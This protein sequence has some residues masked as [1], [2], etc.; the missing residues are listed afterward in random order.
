MEYEMVLPVNDIREHLE[1]DLAC[2]CN[3]IWEVLPSGNL[4]LI[5]NSFD[6][7]ELMEDFFDRVAT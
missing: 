7:R 3:P 1:S 6:G 4:V 2:P 5:H